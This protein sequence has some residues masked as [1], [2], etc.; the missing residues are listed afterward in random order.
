MANVTCRR[1]FPERSFVALCAAV[2]AACGAPSSPSISLDR[3][4]PRQPFVVVSGLSRADIRTIGEA[5]PAAWAAM[6]RVSVV[7]EASDR[8]PAVAGRYD[9]RNGILRFTPMFPLDP[10]R[11]YDV[12]FDPAAARGVTGIP[13]ASSRVT[14][15]ALSDDVAPPTTVSI[16]Y[17]GATDVPANLLRMYIEFSAPMGSR[18]GQ[19]YVAIL[20]AQGRDM[21]DA[22]LPLDTGLWN[23]DHTRFTVLFDPGRVKRGILPNRRAGRPLHPGGTFSI[24]VRRDWPDG[25]AR[26]L[27]AD[28]RRKYRVGPAIERALNPSDWR[29]TAPAAGSRDPL[30]VEFP[31]PLDH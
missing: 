13:G 26:P 28:F 6:F 24:V 30:V 27:A 25:R 4:N 10:G 22:V 7:T 16:V 5:G 2:L 17:P 8:T 1:L 18:D 3:S 15:P 20:D 12:V 19:S 11:S 31:W 21:Q 23:P 14:V 29:I 9:I